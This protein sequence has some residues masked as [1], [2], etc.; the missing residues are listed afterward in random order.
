MIVTKPGRGRKY[1]MTGAAKRAEVM[2]RL[3]RRPEGD[4]IPKPLVDGEERQPAP[5]A[6]SA[7]ASTAG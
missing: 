4:Q 2:R 3:L 7:Q 5:I 1:A 6:R